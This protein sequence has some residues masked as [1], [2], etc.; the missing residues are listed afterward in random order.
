MTRLSFCLLL[1]LLAGVTAC[2]DDDF[3]NEARLLRLRLLAIQAEPVNP[4][5]GTTTRLRPLVYVPPGES[6]TYE[7]SW[8]PVPTNPNDGYIC[9]IDQAAVDQIG[10]MT[11]LSGIPPL[12]LGNGE[13]VDFQ[14]P[15]PPALLASLC[16][17]D[18]ATIGMLVGTDNTGQIPQLYDCTVATLAM[19]VKLTIRGSTTDTGVVSLRLPIDENTPSN[20]NP[21]ITGVTVTSI[22]PPTLL[23]QTGLVHVSR[24]SEVKVRAELD[25]TQAETYL[26]KQP[27]QDGIYQKDSTGKFI[28][29]ARTEALTL[30]WF[31]ENSKF[32]NRTTG[33][34][35]TSLDENGQKL[36]FKVATENTW[37]ISNSDDYPGSTALLLVVVRDNRGGVAWAQGMA[38]LDPKESP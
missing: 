7:W 25:S 26:D 20:Q 6:V 36:L 11:G 37:K 9:P 14:N 10:A 29:A 15:F 33:W 5:F 34:N 17:G 18:S 35:A 21:I 31:A 3:P 38:T 19:Q 16:A 1:P 24:E 28:L 22:E 2:A 32:E 30:S 8:C 12:A 13:T 23:D 27:G 4:T